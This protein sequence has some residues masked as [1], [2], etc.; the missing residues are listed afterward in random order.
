MTILDADEQAA[1][2]AI[3]AAMAAVQRIGGDRL[4]D[5]QRTE[6]VIGVHLLQSYVVQHAL[7]RHDPDGFSSWYEPVAPDPSPT[8]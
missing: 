3:L 2:D 6:L 7:A 5:G 8:P 4:R 1:M